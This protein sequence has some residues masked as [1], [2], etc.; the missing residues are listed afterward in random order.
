MALPNVLAQLKVLFAAF[1]GS[2]PNANPPTLGVLPLARGGLGVN[3]LALAMAQFGTI[4]RFLT[5]G[6]NINNYIGP[7][8]AGIHMFNTSGNHIG[9]PSDFTGHGCLLVITDTRTDITSGRTIHI[10][11]PS[12]SA[13]TP[14]NTWYYRASNYEN[15]T[16][17]PWGKYNF[18]R[19]A[20]SDE[21]LAAIS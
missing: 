21:V 15:G 18:T 19:I 1:T 16:W 6:S 13:N 10:I 17:S 12:G 9:M 7:N 4:D 5:A 3:S 8:Y 20:T 14:L 11:L 2:N